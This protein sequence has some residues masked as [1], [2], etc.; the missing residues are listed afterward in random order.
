MDYGPCWSRLDDW[1]GTCIGRVV[2][3][4]F[5]AARV[6]MDAPSGLAR[7][8]CYHDNRRGELEC[9][10]TVVEDKRAAGAW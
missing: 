4:A 8:F 10:G 5:T 9:G 2:A 7:A 1:D 6:A 3:S